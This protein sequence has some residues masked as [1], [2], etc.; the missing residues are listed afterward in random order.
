RRRLQTGDDLRAVERRAVAR[1]LDHAH[2]HLV[3][4]LERCEA[5]PA[6]QALA[7]APDRGAV[8]GKAG[9]DDLVVEARARGAAHPAKLSAGVARSVPGPPLG[10][11]MRYRSTMRSPTRSALP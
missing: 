10:R 7:T 6:R 11:A 8:V 5:P 4:P 2:R 1:A 9:V 3:E